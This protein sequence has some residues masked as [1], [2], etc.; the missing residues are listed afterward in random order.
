MAS[1]HTAH[2][3][4]NFTSGSRDNPADR[5]NRKSYQVVLTEEERPGQDVMT[6]LQT[7]KR[8]MIGWHAIPAHTHKRKIEASCHDILACTEEPRSSQVVM[9]FLHT[10]KNTDQDKLS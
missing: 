8:K 1:L 10:Q 6:C 7:K 2:R 3:R 9:T 5:E 4:T